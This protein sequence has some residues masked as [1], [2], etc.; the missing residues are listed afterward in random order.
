MPGCTRAVSPAGSSATMRFMYFEKSRMTATLQH[1]PARL[2]PPPRGSTGAPNS[3]HA[4]RVA[5]TSASSSGTT[6]PIGTWR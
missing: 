5:C 1:W 6:R 4:A 2:V 3:R